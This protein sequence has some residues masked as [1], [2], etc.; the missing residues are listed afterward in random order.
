MNRLF[1][2]VALVGLLSAAPFA[3]AEPELIAQRD[4][5]SPRYYELLRARAEDLSFCF[6]QNSICATSNDMWDNCYDQTGGQSKNATGWFTCICTSG[7]VSVDQACDFCQDV[8]SIEHLDV[9]SIYTSGCSSVGAT[10]API[11]S[12]VLS[13]EAKYNSTYT[14]VIPGA[15]GS[16]GGG[17]GADSGVTT[18]ATATKTT[19]TKTTTTSENG[20][21]SVTSAPGGGVNGVTNNP[22]PQSTVFVTRGPMS[23]GDL[24]IPTGAAVPRAGAGVFASSFLTFVLG[25]ALIL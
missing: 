24:P 15:T 19:T 12:S 20:D 6:G 10:I 22:N 14:G 4:D 21:D 9:R 8:Y 16:P 5:V 2:T 1:K 3:V 11:P 18:P 13:L 25:L 23:G 17:G 7:Y